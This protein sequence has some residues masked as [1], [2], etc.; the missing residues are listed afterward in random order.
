MENILLGIESV[1]TITNLFYCFLGVFLGTVVGV[2]PGLGPV[3]A[4]SILLPVSF[5][6][7][8]PLTS[9]IFLSGIYYGAQYGGS[10][11]SI[12]L[13]LPG[14]TSSVVTAIDGYQMTKNDR[15]GAALAIAAIGSFIAGTFGTI[16][17]AVVGEPIAKMAYLFGPAEYASLM[18]LGLVASISLTNDSLYKGLGMVFIG[19]L[20]GSIGTDVH[21]GIFRFTL[22]NPNLYNGI[23]FI[24]IAMGLFG[25]TEAIM[26]LKEKLEI[27]IKTPKFKELYPSR[28]ELNDS[29]PA[30]ARGTILGTILGILPGTGTIISSFASYALEKRIS[31]T[32][33]DFGKGKI[34]GV[35]GPESANNAAAQTNFVPTLSL[36][37]PG[38]PIMSLIIAALIIHGIQPGPQVISSNP[39]LF[40]GLIISMWLGNLFLLVLNLPLIGIWIQFLKIPKIILFVLICFACTAGTYSIN[41]NWFDIWLLIPFT[42]LGLILRYLDC[43]PAPLALGF[44]IGPMLEDEIRRSLSISQGDWTIFIQTGISSSLLLL[45]TVL[46]I[47]SILFRKRVDKSHV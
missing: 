15:G 36:G 32:P 30:I 11:T 9:I 5:T 2:L 24:I 16:I 6:L 33:E 45:S 42:M 25:L 22:D 34:Q 1:F 40:W 26:S 44:V 4:A 10:T 13:N 31:K 27:E 43:N 28:Q 39:E 18:V 14:E 20:L 3:G 17:L 38:T 47:S 29:I 41:N 46:V 37:I 21:S 12:L 23:S 19:I 8:N 35:A 7:A